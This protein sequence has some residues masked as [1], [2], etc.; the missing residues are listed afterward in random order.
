MLKTR[1]VLFSGTPCQ[2][3]GLYRFLGERPEHLT[4][5]DL[6]CHGVPSPGVWES[7]AADQAERKRKAVSTVCFRSKTAGWH[8]SYLT[9]RY[10]DGSQDSAPLYETEYGRGFG[11]SL[12]LRESCFRCPYSSLS[13]VGD[14]T[15]GDFWGLR[16]EELPEQQEKGVSLLLI[17]TPHG[18][19]VFDRLDIGCKQYPA[20]RAVAGNPRLASPT[21]YCPERSAFFA[22]YALEPFAQVRKKFLTLQPYLVRAASKALT[23]ALKAKVKKVLKR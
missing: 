1:P 11:R 2:V 13:R 5:C 16:P 19:H 12:F 3:D 23:P 7:F 14:L 8:N 6:V 4:T 22:A 9:L 15:L 20:E 10:E 17:N 18:S 21:A